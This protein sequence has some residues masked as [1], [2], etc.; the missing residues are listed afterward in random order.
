M[1][2]ADEDDDAEDA[3]EAANCE[4]MT[5]L[6]RLSAAGII[7]PTLTLDADD[8]AVITVAAEW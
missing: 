2:T 5:T 4:A 3:D 8:C 6:G 1:F 7:P